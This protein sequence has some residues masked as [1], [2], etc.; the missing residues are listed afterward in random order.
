MVALRSFSILAL[1]KEAN[2]QDP[3]V[4]VILPEQS[5]LQRNTGRLQGLF[6]AI[7]ATFFLYSVW[8]GRPIE[9]EI[10][11]SA[12]QAASTNW[13][14]IMVYAVVVIALVS[15]SYWVLIKKERRDEAWRIIKDEWWAKIDAPASHGKRFVVITLAVSIAYLEF[16]IAGSVWFALVFLLIMAVIRP[17]K[18]KI[19]LGFLVFDLMVVILAAFFPGAKLIRTEAYKTAD[20]TLS[21]TAEKMAGFNK[22][23]REGKA[24]LFS[25]PPTT[26]HVTRS[27][28]KTAHVEAFPGNPND[29][30]SYTW[31]EKIPD[32]STVSEFTCPGGVYMKVIHKMNPGGRVYDCDGYEYP[33]WNGMINLEIGFVSKTNEIVRFPISIT[34]S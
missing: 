34:G 9:Q 14:A 10:S 1:T 12:T 15:A 18:D 31:V 11:P 13:H 28:S 5:W 23:Y 2:M 3:E 33:V 8:T 21:K 19:T 22:D 24:G 4:N 25:S 27:N 26:G 6:V 17:P 7:I 30:N 29:D 20:I 16:H 32:H